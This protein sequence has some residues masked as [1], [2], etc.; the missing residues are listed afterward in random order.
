MR[1]KKTSKTKSTPSD[2]LFKKIM[3][4]P[5]AAREFLEYY[6]PD[7]FKELIDLS[8]IKLEKES[9][10]ESNLKKRLSDIVYS[11]ETLGNKKAYIYVLIE[12]QSTC[13]YWIS[14]RL[15]KYILLL[16]EKHQ[17]DKNKLPLVAPILFY[18]GIKK[19]H[20]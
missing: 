8:K 4:N 6:L 16:L 13:D 9:Y 15:W 1:K 7:D 20:C 14:L 18:N 2:A 5:V 17:T 10:V 19:W 3:E 12:H 11:V